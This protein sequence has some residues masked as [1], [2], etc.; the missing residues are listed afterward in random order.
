MEAEIVDLVAGAP[1]EV[2][3]ARIARR[4][5]RGEA[6]LGDGKRGKAELPQAGKD[7]LPEHLP[8][9]VRTAAGQV[10]VLQAAPIFSRC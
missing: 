4:R 8:G 10:R 6:R 7:R 1:G 5:E 9:L 3:P 2:Y